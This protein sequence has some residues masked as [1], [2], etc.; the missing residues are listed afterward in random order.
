[1]GRHERE[2]SAGGRKRDRTWRVD[3]QSVGV[4]PERDQRL[5]SVC[6][7]S[8][9]LPILQGGQKAVTVKML[10]GIPHKRCFSAICRQ[11]TAHRRR[12]SLELFP[13]I[14]RG[15]FCPARYQLPDEP[16]FIKIQRTH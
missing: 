1:M 15:A 6:L 8:D 2:T 13:P 11:Q 12:P 4:A 9:Q 16:I 7:V 3:L 14:L 5:L 10:R